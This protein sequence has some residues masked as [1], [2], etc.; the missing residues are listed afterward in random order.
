M[1]TS[2]ENCNFCT[3]YNQSATNIGVLTPLFQSAM[4][5]HFWFQ[6]SELFALQICSVCSKKVMDFHLFYST[7]E[8]L[9]A[10]K[11]HH[12]VQDEGNFTEDV[13]V[14]NEPLESELIAEDIPNGQQLIVGDLAFEIVDVSAKTEVFEDENELLEEVKQ[15]VTETLVNNNEA[16]SFDCLNCDKG[17]EDKKILELH[18][19]LVHGDQTAV[20]KCSQCAQLEQALREALEQDIAE[21]SESSSR[22]QCTVCDGMMKNM[23]SLQRHL[24]WHWGETCSMCSRR[25]RNYEPTQEEEDEDEGTDNQAKIKTY[26][27]TFCEKQYIQKKYLKMH[28]EKNH[29]FSPGKCQKCEALDQALEE[30][31]DR[32]ESGE[33]GRVK[34]GVCDA[35]LMSLASFQRHLAWHESEPCESCRRKPRQAEQ[36]FRDYVLSQKRSTSRRSPFVTSQAKKPKVD[37]VRVKHI[38]VYC[39]LYFDMHA[40]LI[41]HQVEEHP[42]RKHCKYTSVLTN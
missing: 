36:T 16:T 22:V 25:P 30:L 15:E 8:R 28:M 10:P 33:S 39:G 6:E 32:T 29:K 41:K 7:V 1:E 13:V 31:S 34:C 37:N 21:V 19:K 23:A 11:D 40:K 5:K 42:K 18:M 2:T 14:K 4:A 12:L 26:V 3:D 9:L 38:C 17:F 20:R 24:A 27:C 35:W